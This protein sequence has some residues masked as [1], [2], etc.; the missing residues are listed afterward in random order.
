[1]KPYYVPGEEPL[2]AMNKQLRIIGA[3]VDKRKVYLADGV[4][5]LQELNDLEVLLLETSGSYQ[6]KDERKISFDNIK[7]MF[8][9]LGMM[10]TVADQYSHASVE[11]FQKLKLYYIQ[12]SG[13]YTCV[14]RWLRNELTKY[15]NYR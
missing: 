13:K 2:N 8:A 11:S 6:N 7:G 5:R 14:K 10:K 9:L 4:V 15:L 12:A 3:K 1:M